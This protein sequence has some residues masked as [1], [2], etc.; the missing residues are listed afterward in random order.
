[1]AKQGTL[2]LVEEIPKQGREAESQKW[3]WVEAE[4]W[5]GRMLATLENG[6]KGG[7]MPTL[8]NRAVYHD[9]SPCCDQSVP[10]WTPLTGEPDAGDLHVRFGGGRGRGLTVPSYPYHSGVFTI[11][12]VP[13]SHRLAPTSLRDKNLCIIRARRVS[14]FGARLHRQQWTPLR[15]GSD[16][17][18]AGGR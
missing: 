8:S 13:A 2:P 7:P 6:V 17:E 1:M 15:P 11:L 18:P 9:H 12:T 16:C 3:D 5:T 10:P 4:V 14:R